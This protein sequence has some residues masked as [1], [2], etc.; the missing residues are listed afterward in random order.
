MIGEYEFLMQVAIREYYVTGKE[1]TSPSAILQK[2]YPDLPGYVH[3][4]VATEARFCK[5]QYGHSYN[6]E[7]KFSADTDEYTF[8]DVHLKN[9][10]YV[11]IIVDTDDPT[12]RIFSTI[13]QAQYDMDAP[14][15]TLEHLYAFLKNWC[16]KRLGVINK[17]PGKYN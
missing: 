13:Q 10:Q 2:L 12:L 3:F 11:S 17:D 5:S 7:P 4:L 14:F 9:G 1:L 16:N 6:K 15:D 8:M